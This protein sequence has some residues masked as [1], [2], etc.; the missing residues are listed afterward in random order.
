MLIK[1][2]FEPDE[3]DVQL[4]KPFNIDKFNKARERRFFSDAPLTGGGIYATGLSSKTDPSEYIKMSNSPT[5]LSDDAFYNYV[6]TIKNVIGSNP[7]FPYIRTVVVGKDPTGMTKTYYRMPKLFHYH[8]RIINIE[9]LM[10]IAERTFSLASSLFNTKVWQNANQYLTNEETK[11]AIWRT[12]IIDNLNQLVNQIADTYNQEYKYN[13]YLW[14]RNKKQTNQNLNLDELKKNFDIQFNNWFINSVSKRQWS[15]DDQ[16]LIQAL[17]I[18]VSLMNTNDYTLDITADN[19][20]I[21][22]TAQGPQLVL[23]DPIHDDLRSIIT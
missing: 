8:E 17:A 3:Q 23:N 12:V 9:M 21:R 11:D 22:L 16:Y 18:I 6:Q 13:L 14:K 20:M 7:Y 10:A 5:K 15:T 2:I 1:E 19:V 4:A